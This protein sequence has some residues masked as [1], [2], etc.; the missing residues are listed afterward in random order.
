[1]VR[2]MNTDLRQQYLTKNGIV[3][4][5]KNIQIQIKHTL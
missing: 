5:V 4:K 3:V 2:R 1:M